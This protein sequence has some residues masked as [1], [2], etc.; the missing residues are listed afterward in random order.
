MR[1]VHFS[2]SKSGGAGSVARTLSDALNGLGHESSFEYV[3]G[4]NLRQRPI[5][6]PG[7]TT[8]AVLDEYLI[9]SQEFPNPISVLRANLGSASLESIKTADIVHLHWVPG[10]ISL[11]RLS[12]VFSLA[13]SVVW[14]LH[15]MWPMTGACHYSGACEGYQSSCSNCPAIKKTFWQL[16]ERQLSEKKALVNSVGSKLKVVA[17][18]NWIAGLARSSKVFN[19]QSVTVIPNPVRAKPEV[20]L[21]QKTAAKKA[22][23]IEPSSFVVAFSAANLEDKRKGLDSLLS[24]MEQLAKEL[25]NTNLELLL[26]G[27]SSRKL[28]CPGVKITQPGFLQPPQMKNTLLAS[29]L[30]VN[31]STEENLSI[32]LIEALSLGVPILALDSGGNSDVVQNEKSGY[33][34]TSAREMSQKIRKLIEE[35]HTLSAF[36][37]YATIDFENR[38]RADKV[39]QRYA[40]LYRG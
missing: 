5:K 15:D 10:Q 26:L 29:D 11:N 17:P 30:L 19:N 24:E 9:K 4:S 23:G 1:I 32:A 14:T 35:P 21:L 7:L 27:H 40:D 39:A 37:S 18:S 36:A 25:P 28:S 22:L 38:F 20:P 2:F 3:T 31:L 13:K 34:V 33:L 16:A 6:N 8:A 12:A